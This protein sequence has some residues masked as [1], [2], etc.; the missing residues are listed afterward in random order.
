MVMTKSIIQLNQDAILYL[1]SG[2]HS[3]AKSAL[4]TAYSCLEGAGAAQAVRNYS[5]HTA[6]NTHGPLLP[7]VKSLQI[8][9]RSLNAAN[10]SSSGNDLFTCYRR[11]LSVSELDDAHYSFIARTRMSAVIQYNL[12]LSHHQSG[13]ESNNTKDLEIALQL[14]EGAYFTIERVKNQYRMDDVFLLLL[15]IFFNM[16]HIHCNMFNV[17][18]CEHCLE[19]LKVAL[20]SRECVTLEEGDYLFFS[21]NVSLLSIQMPRLA[22][23]A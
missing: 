4:L 18:E 19:W 13:I 2:M 3:R 15:G 21:T 5:H 6:I 14:Y 7:P 9:D 17:A 22:P 12:A 16:T 20:S 10:V 11:A 23:A 1:R 8:N